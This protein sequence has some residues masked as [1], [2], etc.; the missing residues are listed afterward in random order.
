MELTVVRKIKTPN[1][2]IGDLYINGVKKYVTL[3]DFDRG[4]TSDMTLEEIKAIK[5]KTQT[6]IPTGRYKLSIYKEGKHGE[7]LL[8]NEVPGFSMI[9]IHVG[10]Y[11][12]DTE[13]CLLVGMLVPST[14]DMISQSTPAVEELN[15]IV[16][17]EIKAGRDVY[18][19]YKQADHVATFA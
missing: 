1:S 7:C 4:L 3:E 14:K 10:N 12:K 5:V 19:T 2:T 9:E 6:A 17:A 16:F 13:G 8:V 15:K 18:I 11:P